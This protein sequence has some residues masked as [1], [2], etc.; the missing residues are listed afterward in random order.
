MKKYIIRFIDFNDKLIKEEKVTEGQKITKPKVKR[1]F[2]KFQ[3]WEPAFKKIASENITYKAVYTPKMDYDKNGVSDEEEFLSIISPILNNKEYLKRKTYNHHGKTS[4][5]EHCFAV[6]YYAYIWAK[7]LHLKE[8]KVRNA[9]IA[10]LL[11]D[12][13]YKDWTKNPEHQPLFKKHGFVHAKEAKE[14]SK[15]NFPEYMN[16]RIE[17]AIERHMFPLNIVP[18]RYIE[19]WLVTFSDKFVSFDTIKNYKI[20]FSFFIKKYR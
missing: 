18:P 5:Y 13:Y 20:L 1:Y 11:H 15:K 2:Y 12:F 8:E 14:N 6:S 3:G 7:K 9:S 17:N 10:G 4:V 16:K 19:S